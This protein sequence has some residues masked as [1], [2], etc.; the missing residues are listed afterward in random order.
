MAGDY[1]MDID[2]TDIEAMPMHGLLFGEDQ[3]RYVVTL[4]RD[5]AQFIANSAADQGISARIL[6]TVSGDSLEVKDV[7][8]LDV[9][10]MKTAHENWF[11][12]YMT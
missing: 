3:A 5:M 11:P 1:G 9:K 2:L 6:G 8:S 10:A 7:L 4:D 12:N